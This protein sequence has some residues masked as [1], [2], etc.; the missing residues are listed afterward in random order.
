MASQTNFTILFIPGY[1][2]PSFLYYYFLKD[3]RKSWNLEFAYKWNIGS[4]EDNAKVIHQKISKKRQSVY[5]IAHSKGGLD[6]KYYLDNYSSSK[7]VLHTITISTPW[8]STPFDI[9]RSNK[10]WDLGPSKQVLSNIRHNKNS[11]S[12][13]TSLQSK[14]DEVIGF[15]N[16]KTLPSAQNSIIDTVGHFSI[17]YSSKISRKVL[18][19]LH[20]L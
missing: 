18:D 17:C 16:A 10:L 9:F 6:A 5:I 3:L 1:C 13:I 4:I 15:S 19:T 7:R 20:M 8:S 12:K 11:I 14:F 2:L